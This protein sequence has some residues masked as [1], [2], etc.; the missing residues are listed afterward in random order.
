M[1]LSDDE[2]SV[3]ADLALRLMIEGVGDQEVARVLF[4][5]DKPPYESIHRTTWQDLEDRQLIKPFPAAGPIRYVL[6]ATGWL[7]GLEVSDAHEAPEMKDKIARLM[8]E[9]KK[10]VKDRNEKGRAHS[11]IIAHDAGVPASFVHNI[12][13]SNFIERVLKR[14]GVSYRVASPGYSI[15]IPIN[16][17]HPLP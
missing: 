11:H 7:K 1:T 3:N 2:R 8:G 4:P 13:E 6:T 9:L 14:K 16:F 10:Y 12:L 5:I 15:E 17:D